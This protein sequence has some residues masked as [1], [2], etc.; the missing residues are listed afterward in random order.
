ML[1]DWPHNDKPILYHTSMKEVNFAEYSELCIYNDLISKTHLFP[2]L[3]K[4]ACLFR[5]Q[6][7]D[8][9]LVPLGSSLFSLFVVDVKIYLV[10]CDDLVSIPVDRSLQSVDD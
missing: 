1:V 3:E 6:W 7:V 5:S 8:C 9:G 10:L 2:S 4:L